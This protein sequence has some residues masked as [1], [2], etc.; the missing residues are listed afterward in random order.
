MRKM[1]YLSNKK[2]FTCQIPKPDNIKITTIYTKYSFAF[3]KALGIPPG[4]L[5]P[6]VA[7]NC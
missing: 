5:P 1:V 2:E 3:S 7:K 6:A 4:F